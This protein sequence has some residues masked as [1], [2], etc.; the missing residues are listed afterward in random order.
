MRKLYLIKLLIVVISF[1]SC[2]ESENV[3]SISKLTSNPYKISV[4][5]AKSIAVN[6]AAK[7][8]VLDFMQV[9]QGS[10]SCKTRT[11]MRNLEIESVEI[12]DAN[13]VITR[14]VGIEDTLLYAVNFSNNGGY[15]LVGADRRTEP[16]FGV[17]DNG[18]FF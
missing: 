14:S 11:K 13:K 1:S 3:E 7:D 9:F 15:V 8:I 6:H 17:I 18:S 4:D 5:E 16:I 10:D 12:V 2:Q